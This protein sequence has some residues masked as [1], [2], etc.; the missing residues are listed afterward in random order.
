M[1]F[2]QHIL[3]VANS[4]TIKEAEQIKQTVDSYADAEIKLS[5]VYVTPGI[6]T[7]YYQLPSIANLKAQMLDEIKGHLKKLGALLSVAEQDQWIKTGRLKHEVQRLTQYLNVDVI[8][9]NSLANSDTSTA[10]DPILTKKL[11]RQPFKIPSRKF[12][13]YLANLSACVIPALFA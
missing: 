4:L 12:S 1:L 10:V 11:W 5:L 2:R 13:D 7:Q 3:I 9:T 6:P 8:I